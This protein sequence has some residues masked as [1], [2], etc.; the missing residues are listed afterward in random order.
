MGPD[1]GARRG[2]PRDV[3]R[4]RR[5]ARR[6]RRGAGVAA[7]PLGLPRRSGIVREAGAWARDYQGEELVTESAVGRRPFFAATEQLRDAVAAAGPL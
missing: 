3:R 2:D 7:A 4:R 5:L 6:L 1:P